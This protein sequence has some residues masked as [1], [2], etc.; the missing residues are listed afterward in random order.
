M[1][2]Q[3]DL[4]LDSLAGLLNAESNNGKYLSLLLDEQ[5]I[6]QI[7]EVCDATVVE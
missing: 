1:L 4:S 3:D 6:G 5:K 7:V 2:T